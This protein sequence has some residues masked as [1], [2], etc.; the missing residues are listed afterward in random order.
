[1]RVK[2][3]D[4]RQAI[5]DAAMQ[6]FREVGYERASMAEISARVGGSKATL[7]S[8]FKSKEE[9]YAT[10]MVEAVE[11]QRQQ[12]LSRLDLSSADMAQVLEDFGKALLTLVTDPEV[13]AILRTAMAEGASSSLGPVLYDR[14]PRSVWNEVAAYL[15]RL[16]ETGALRPGDAEVAALHFKGLLEAG[17]FEP[18]LYGASPRMSIEAGAR[19]AVATFLRAYG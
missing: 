14:G 15:A 2:T 7:Y 5:I 4:R 12:M 9:L 3:E 13:L 18:A 11:E 6:V 10:G 17:I 16:M 19:R 1:M 8:Y